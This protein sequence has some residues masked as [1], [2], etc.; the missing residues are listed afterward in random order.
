M[1][2]TLHPAA[3][4]DLLEAAEFH[5]RAG[6]PALAAR[7]VAEF[8]RMASLL[9]AQPEIGLTVASLA[10]AEQIAEE[11]GGLVYS[12]LWPGP[13][14]KVRNVCD[15]EGNVVHLRELLA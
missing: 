5:E 7:F 6:S 4:R 10:S 9:L 13:G 8:K 3:E 2:I 11:C 15:P 1:R 14:M 12:P